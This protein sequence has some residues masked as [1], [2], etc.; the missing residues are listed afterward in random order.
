[1]PHLLLKSIPECPR[2][3]MGNQLVASVFWVGATLGATVPNRE[4]II[5]WNQ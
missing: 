5:L 4:A 1:L 2:T 3:D